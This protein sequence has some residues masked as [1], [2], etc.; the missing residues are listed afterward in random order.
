MGL[1]L[2]PVRSLLTAQTQAGGIHLLRLADANARCVDYARDVL[3]GLDGSLFVQPSQVC[4]TFFFGYK[5]A[6]A[7]LWID[8]TNNLAQA[9]AQLAG[10]LGSALD[11]WTDPVSDN[12]RAAAVEIFGAIRNNI[13]NF[14]GQIHA[15]GW[16]YGGAIASVLP[17][18]APLATYPDATWGVTTFG[19]PRVGGSQQCRDIR[20]ACDMGRWMND[21]DP[22]PLVPP[23]VADFPPILPLFGIRG[24]TRAENFLHPDGGVAIFSDGRVQSNN[25][26]PAGVIN[27][28]AGITDWLLASDADPTSPHNIAQYRVRI[29]TALQR[30]DGHAR[31]PAPA[32]ERPQANARREISRRAA[33]VVHQVQELGQVQGDIPVVVPRDKRF[34]WYKLGGL[35]ITAF[36][37]L[38][39]ATSNT[40]KRAR[41]LAN[42]GNDFLER[43]QA[44]AVVDPGALLQQ[45]TNYVE[46]AT[47]PA[48]GFTPTMN[49][50]FPS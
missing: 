47:D 39:V 35:F 9:R 7:V 11:S 26:P 16:S 40:K 32:P 21:N 41:H 31:E 45:F 30:N 12:L 42:A 2:T 46:L 6:N 20:A 13:G 43:L 3:D 14:F 10:Y 37:D 44:Q 48:S 49:T 5:V 19:A 50:K 18:V 38:T 4:P 24:C 29:Q 27:F 17:I 8:G 33:A 22:I 36:G 1:P 15:A 34:V 25:V 23:R 28:V